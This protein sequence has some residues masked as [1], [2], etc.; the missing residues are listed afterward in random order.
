[1]INGRTKLRI[2]ALPLIALLLLVKIQY[3]KYEDYGSPNSIVQIRG[4]AI[5]QDPLTLK[6]D[7]FEIKLHGLYVNDMPKNCETL[8]KDHCDTLL[9]KQLNS[10]TDGKKVNCNILHK[11]DT[12]HGY[13]DCFIKEQNI[14]KPLLKLGNVSQY[15]IPYIPINPQFLD[16]KSHKLILFKNPEDV[17]QQRLQQYSSRVIQ[18]N[19]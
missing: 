7:N 9:R 1:M 8:A 6:I 19:G 11:I 2:A 4:I 13:G 17:I 16:I 15:P 14:N 5:V 3:E 18:P 12:S 10:I